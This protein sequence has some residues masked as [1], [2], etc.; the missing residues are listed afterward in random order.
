M[1][2]F[3]K[4]LALLSLAVLACSINNRHATPRTGTL[5]R[6]RSATANYYE[7]LND[8]LHEINAVLDTDDPSALIPLSHVLH[9]QDHEVFRL[10]ILQ[11]QRSATQ[12]CLTRQGRAG[13][14]AV[15]RACLHSAQ[16]EVLSTF[17]FMYEAELRSSDVPWSLAGDIR[18]LMHSPD[19]SKEV[20]DFL[21][22]FV[23]TVQDRLKAK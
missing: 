8:V 20:R 13:V 12:I 5:E 17:E 6:L 18:D 21:T 15:V 2:N 10:G 19:E 16:P 22:Q 9:Y 11:C 1:G 4:R 7:A 3:V 14:R 23:A